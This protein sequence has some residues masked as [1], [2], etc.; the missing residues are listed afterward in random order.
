MMDISVGEHNK[1][2]KNSTSKHKIK[3]KGTQQF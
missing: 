1:K 2:K 3:Y